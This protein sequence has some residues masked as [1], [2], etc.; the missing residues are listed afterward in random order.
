[1]ELNLKM[2]E[3]LIYFALKYKGNWELIHSAINLKEEIDINYLNVEMGKIKCN[4]VTLIDQNYPEQLKKIYQP[5]FVLFY[6]GDLSLLKN[7]SFSIVTLLYLLFH[8]NTK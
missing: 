5:P 8:S 2:R 7:D 3:V 1:M 6:Y 4:I